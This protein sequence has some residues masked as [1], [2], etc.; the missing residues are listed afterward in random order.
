MARHPSIVT[1]T[2]RGPGLVRVERRLA[3]VQQQL[4]RADFGSHPIG[5]VRE[6]A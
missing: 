4:E 5:D 6:L 2:S 3:Q 1:G